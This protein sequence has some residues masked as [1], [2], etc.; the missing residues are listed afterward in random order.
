MNKQQR[1]TDR[2]ERKMSKQQREADRNRKADEPRT[3]RDREEEK[4]R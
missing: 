4:R 1:E 2:L 3:K